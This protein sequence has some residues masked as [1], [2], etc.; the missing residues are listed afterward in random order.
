M[1]TKQQVAEI[2]EGM[3]RYY[4]GA[5]RMIDHGL[6]LE[7]IDQDG[8]PA[9]YR[10]GATSSEIRAFWAGAAYELRLSANMFRS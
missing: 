3:A 9:Q 2:L 1:Y 5:F 10:D 8:G 7:E 6:T 4:E